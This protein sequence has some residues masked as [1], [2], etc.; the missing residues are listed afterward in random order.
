MSA[1]V[2][3]FIGMLIGSVIGGYIPT[4]FGADL[5]SYSSVLFSGIGSLI[6]IF[7]AYKVSQF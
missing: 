4:F 1:K 5:I 2:L 7:I 3:I 6:G